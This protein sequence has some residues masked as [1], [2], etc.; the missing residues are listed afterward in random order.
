MPYYS[1][2]KNSVGKTLK[3]P[4]CA[5]CEDIINVAIPK[6][7]DFPGF[8]RFASSE[9]YSA[10]EYSA[11]QG[12]AVCRLVLA[13]FQSPSYL[14]MN[15]NSSGGGALSNVQRFPWS[16][17]Q[18]TDITILWPELSRF[19]Q[20]FV[21]FGRAAA[22]EESANDIERSSIQEG[23][24]GPMQ[25]LLFG[26]KFKSTASIT[27]ANKWVQNCINN[28]ERYSLCIIQN[29][30]N[31]WLKE[32]ALMANVCGGSRFN[33]AATGAR[34]SNDGL[35]FERDLNLVWAVELMTQVEDQ[36]TC[37]K[38]DDSKRDNSRLAWVCVDGSMHR[39]A[40]RPLPLRGPRINKS[41]D[42]KL[43]HQSSPDVQ[44]GPPPLVPQI[45]GGHDCEEGL[46][47][48]PVASKKGVFTR[49]RIY[50]TPAYGGTLQ[51]FEN[52]RNKGRLPLE[53]ELSLYQKYQGSTEQLFE[54]ML[55][56]LSNKSELTSPHI[57]KSSCQ[58]RLEIPDFM[59]KKRP[60]L[61]S[62][63]DDRWSNGQ[64][65]SWKPRANAL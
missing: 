4:I 26:K 9:S 34:N 36:E 7:K 39:R 58:M 65:F 35:F 38:V 24:L 45:G 3:F 12:R 21:V 54:R 41:E 20:I 44:W 2:A 8:R 48:A 51:D 55:S 62:G 59:A 50:Q 60:S 64:V 56:L 13:I 33:I 46:I 43:S 63:R 1:L 53:N 49:V 47:I 40:S 5:D 25:T 10:I 11:R 18:H 30:G 29:D 37:S 42:P 28:Y 57:T 14:A 22:Y 23:G 15:N 52:V 6:S 27:L 32:S 19:K 31:Y 16:E 61:S 17:N